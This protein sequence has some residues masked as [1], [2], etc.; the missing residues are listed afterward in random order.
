VLVAVG[1]SHPPG[2]NRQPTG[3]QNETD[4]RYAVRDFDFGQIRIA[5]DWLLVLAE[6]SIVQN[7]LY[8]FSVR[9][10]LP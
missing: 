6:L 8:R 7:L 10:A 9:P 4:G 1:W 2:L 3:W 5:V